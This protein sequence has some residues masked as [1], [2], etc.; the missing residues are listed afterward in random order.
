M[1]TIQLPAPACSL[2]L[3]ATASQRAR[4]IVAAIDGSDASDSALLCARAIARQLSATMRVVT[5]ANLPP[6]LAP[7]MQF[8]LTVEL[9]H[10]HREQWHR[11]A[12]AQVARVLG[13]EPD[14]PVQLQLASG[15]PASTIGATAGELGAEL[16]VAGIGRHALS[17]RLLGAE[18]A[19]KL[20]HLGVAPVFC[21]AEH[22]MSLASRVLIATDFSRW[23]DD[24]ARLALQYLHPSATV[25]LAHV[26]P[27]AIGAPGLS[28]GAPAPDYVE[29]GFARLER[30]FEAPPTM[31][32]ERLLL[33]G[34]AAPELIAFAKAARIDLIVSGSHGLGVMGRI[35]M[36]SVST[37]LVRGAPCS[38]FVA[39]R[40]WLERRH[41]ERR[42]SQRVGQSPTEASRLLRQ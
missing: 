18:V 24:S 5:V 19:L 36:G 38:V 4:T 1:S 26:Q 22:A 9:E 20:V 39:P 7:E 33:R 10:V 23:S 30:H 11:R 37:R 31:K 16:I 17:D 2:P 13:E 14:L 40:A 6:M 28:M 25:Y 42:R 34:D 3:P 21:V 29:D 8:A 41:V 32:F 35:L 15:D 12:R 27:G